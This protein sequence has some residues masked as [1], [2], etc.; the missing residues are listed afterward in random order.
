M[1][2]S[3]VFLWGKYEIMT[4]LRQFLSYVSF[5]LPYKVG[6]PWWSRRLEGNGFG[7]HLLRNCV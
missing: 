7:I 5:L 2:I 3:L 1:F 6:A 4:L